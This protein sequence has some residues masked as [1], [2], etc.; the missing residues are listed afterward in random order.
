MRPVIVHFDDYAQ[1]A[2]EVERLGDGR[3]VVYVPSAP[4]PRAG[5]VLVFDEARVEYVAMSFVAAIGSVRA[6]GRGF[7]CALYPATSATRSV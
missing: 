4:D 5:A 3:K 6:L 1:L 2:F 7:G